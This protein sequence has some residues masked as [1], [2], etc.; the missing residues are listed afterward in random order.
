MI[1]KIKGLKKREKKNAFFCCEVHPLFFFFFLHRFK[2]FK[3]PEDIPQISAVSCYQSAF[4][5]FF[6]PFFLGVLR[7]A[8]LLIKL[9]HC[10][11]SS[12]RL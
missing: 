3:V 5:C 11:A 1:W 2:K 9:A 12:L 7:S 6:F 4:F 10:A 8:L